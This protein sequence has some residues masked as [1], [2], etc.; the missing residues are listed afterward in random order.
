MKVGLSF[1]KKGRS[2]EER[3]YDFALPEPNSG[4]WIWTGALYGS[5]YGCFLRQQAHRVAWELHNGS[6]PDGL[7]VC[8][9]C[10]FRPCV[11]PE[12]LFIGT[13]SDNLNDMHAKGRNN[14]PRGSKHFKARL[15][16]EDVI[17]IRRDTRR[18]HEIG[19]D[20]GVDKQYV[21]KIKKGFYWRHLRVTHELD[22]RQNGRKFRA[23]GEAHHKAVLTAA[24]VRVI[25][26]SMLS[27]RALGRQYGVSKTTILAIRNNVIWKHIPCV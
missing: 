26:A 12:H 23:R 21:H 6:I 2:V 20:Y 24:E 14:T 22:R 27:S 1:R 3:F 15:T 4:C 11:N 5:G 19:A 17:A 7:L 10:D 16:E 8:H 18:L 9:R 13:Q 25:R